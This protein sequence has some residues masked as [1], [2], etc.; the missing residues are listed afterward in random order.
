VQFSGFSTILRLE[1]EVGHAAGRQSQSP[2]LVEVLIMRCHANW[3]RGW[4]LRCTSVVFLAIATCI[5]WASTAHGQEA[6][7]APGK[8]NCTAE[9][10]RDATEQAIRQA[11]KMKSDY[12]FKETPLEDVAKALTKL[13]KVPFVLDTKALADVGFASDIPITFSVHGISVRSALRLM[14]KQ[15]GLTWMIQ[16]EVVLVTTP[17]EAENHLITK[18]YPVQDLITTKPSYQFEGMYVPGINSGKFPRTLPSRP[19]AFGPF[20][21]DLGSGVV[22]PGTSKGFMR[23]TDESDPFKGATGASHDQP[24]PQAKSSAPA[25]AAG[26]PEPHRAPQI[27]PRETDMSFTMDD[28]IEIIKTCILPT[29]WD[30]TGGSGSIF[31]MAGSL[32]ISQNQ[33]VHE[34]VE[35]LLCLLRTNNP[36]LQVVT[37][38][39]TWLLLDLKQ[40]NQL[41][42]SKQGGIDPKAFAAMTAKVKGGVGTIAGFSGQTVH[43]ASGFNPAVASGMNAILEAGRIP[44]P[45]PGIGG[46]QTGV[47]LQVT[48]QL[49]AGAQTALLD[50]CSS[51]TR[52]VDS[53]Q[54]VLPLFVEQLATTLKVTLGEPTL[55]GGI[56]S[57]VRG[58]AESPEGATGVPQL[59]L[60]VEATAK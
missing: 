34:E 51:V 2:F 9:T 44:G 10:G 3:S 17:E 36:Q 29:F 41:T 37:V 1:R 59:Y 30:D 14:L 52:T 23:V 21:G 49:L 26:V 22:A 28:L 11:F 24:S 56:A 31:P 6:A 47:M 42:G 13:T 19:G 20:T 16:D 35:D 58:E 50:I 5:V 54:T 39:A 32:V 45:Q 55:V 43:I 53:P 46:P 18:I 27:E 33:E 4:E 8:P 60:F 12:E 57:T 40:L 15:H 48:P 7:A 25:G 38:R